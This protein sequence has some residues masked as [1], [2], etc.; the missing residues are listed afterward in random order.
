LRYIFWCNQVLGIN[1]GHK[2]H[3]LDSRYI[4]VQWLVRTKKPSW[5]PRLDTIIDRLETHI[6]D[7]GAAN[8]MSLLSIHGS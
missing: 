6:Y 5:I 2:D 4:E 8:F 1:F 7:M 3:D